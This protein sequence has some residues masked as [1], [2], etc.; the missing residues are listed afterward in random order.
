L[1]GYRLNRLHHVQVSPPPSSV[2]DDRHLYTYEHEPSLYQM[3]EQEHQTLDC[4]E[5]RLVA[6]KRRRQ[7]GEVAIGKR[8][9]TETARVSVR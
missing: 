4:Y 2:S 6:N 7:T 3:N 8:I 1:P 9:E 5:E